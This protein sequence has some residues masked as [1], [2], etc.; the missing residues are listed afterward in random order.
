MQE[1]LGL[2]IK[3][4]SLQTI[5]RADLLHLN[6]IFL[7]LLEAGLIV[8]SLSLQDGH[9]LLQVSHLSTRH[10]HL[11]SHHSGRGQLSYGEEQQL[12]VCTQLAVRVCVYGVCIVCVCVRACEQQEK[13]REGL[14]QQPRCLVHAG[15]CQLT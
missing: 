9:L 14:S 8:L 7:Q 13:G 3:M 6:A 4:L 10:F 5:V 1:P 2:E 12:H 11:L 15:S